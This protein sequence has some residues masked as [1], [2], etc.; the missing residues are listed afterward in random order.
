MFFLLGMVIIKVF[1]DEKKSI[2]QYIATFRQIHT[3]KLEISSRV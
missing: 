3:D 1:T 2:N